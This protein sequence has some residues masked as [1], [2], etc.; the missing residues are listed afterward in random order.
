MACFHH[1][2]VSRN[3]SSRACAA[4]LAAAPSVHFLPAA[5]AQLRVLKPTSAWVAWRLINFE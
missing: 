1:E 5:R 3:P 2:I 4:R